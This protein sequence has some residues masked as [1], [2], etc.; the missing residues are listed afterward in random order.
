MSYLYEEI[1]SE[2]EN[3][4]L[5][6]TVRA[7]DRIPSV[8]R[9]SERKKV[10]VST[11]LQAYLALEGRG[12][13]ESRPQSGYFVRAVALDR[14]P[15]PTLTSAEKSPTSIGVC[16]LAR[17][18]M[19]AD[20][21]PGVFGFAS[22]EI[23][24]ELLPTAEIQR[25]IHTASREM[26]AEMHRYF[27]PP[28]HPELVRAVA[29]RLLGFGC[30]VDPSELTITIGGMEAL[31]L[32]VRAV[33][34][35][36]DCV[37]VESPTYYGILQVLEGLGIRAIEIP[38]DPRTGLDLDTLK[39]VLERSSPKALICVPDFQ[40][41]LG[42]RMSAD[43]K[44][45]LYR[46]AVK[47]DLPIIEDFVYGELAYDGD[48]C[49]TIKQFDKK[50]LVMLLS[51]FSKSLSPG[52]R[53][54][55]IA[56]GRFAQIIQNLKFVNTLSNPGLLQAA[57]ALCLKSGVYDRQL[58]RLRPKLQS[59][60]LSMQ[61]AVGRAFP[62]GTKFTRP[63]GGFVLWVELPD[64]LAGRGPTDVMEIYADALRAGIS[65]A[66]GPIF[67]ASGRFRNCFRLN[68]GGPFT[69]ETERAIARLGDLCR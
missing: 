35:S 7:G 10:S 31:N 65:F 20:I 63:T 39:K 3:Q 28:G 46:L 42:S 12:L 53:T 48:L 14:S 13:I 21:R 11:V 32:A 33:A 45:D 5:R 40:N 47:H 15:E 34:K 62:E 59:Q 4:I 29:N 64:R 55:W 67:S 41:P 61:S 43:R 16:D 25:A 18:V 54:G 26:G 24:P 36:G 56:G 37:L 50:G 2:I 23:A 17:S 27:R 51:S 22:A 69:A 58:K 9:L 44:L 52:L 8:R 38:M 6:G 68:C 57:T 60:M 49:R 30:P 66:P 1:A 19:T